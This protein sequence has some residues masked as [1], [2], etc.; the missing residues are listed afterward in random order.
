AGLVYLPD[1][2][3]MFFHMWVEAYVG[4]RF[5]PLDATVGRGGIGA[6][7]LKLVNSSM[8]G[9]SAF[10]AFLPIIRVIGR[11]DIEVLETP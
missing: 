11:L 10:T 8:D 1:R 9:S 5:I 4:G 6:A 2:R 7:H 3:A